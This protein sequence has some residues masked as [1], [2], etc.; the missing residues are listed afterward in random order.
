MKRLLI[1]AAIL[2]VLCSTPAVAEER[3]IGKIVSAAGADTTNGTTATPFRVPLGSKITMWCDA[4]AYIHIGST[5]AATATGNGLPVAA[6][7]KFPSSVFS[8][9][10]TIKISGQVEP[11]GIVR[12]FGTG[13]VTC[14][15]Y[16]RFGT[17]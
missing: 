3:L 14:Y 9:G 10:P 12:I 7:E 6:S 17:E 13:A 2:A 1:P 8:G 11:S 4:A 15:V 5:S 16:T